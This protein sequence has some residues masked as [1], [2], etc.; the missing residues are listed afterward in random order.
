MGFIR[1]DKEVITGSNHSSGRV[2]IMISMRGS[3]ISGGIH[4]FSINI[5]KYVSINVNYFTRDRVT[6]EVRDIVA[7][8]TDGVINGISGGIS[9]GVSRIVNSSRE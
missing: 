7:R 8:D 4:C 9:I 3:I 5:W 2:I 1:R 6:Y